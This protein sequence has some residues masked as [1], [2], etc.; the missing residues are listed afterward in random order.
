MIKRMLVKDCKE[1]LKEGMKIKT[2]GTVYSLTR[3]GS[4]FEGKITE[5]G[6]HGF[7]FLGSLM[8]DK[9]KVLTFSEWGVA[10]DNHMSWI[11]LDIPDSGKVFELLSSVS[12]EILHIQNI[13]T[14][15]WDNRYVENFAA[16]A[17]SDLADA[18]RLISED[19]NETM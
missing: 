14:A 2:N 18:V 4:Y 11:E 3:V 15:T 7:F 17:Q 1:Y 16:K 6:S 8:E 9:T 13:N 19:K 5:I 12:K 10:Y